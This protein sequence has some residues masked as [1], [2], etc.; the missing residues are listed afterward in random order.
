LLDTLGVPRDRRGIVL[1]C[2]YVMVAAVGL[3][4]LLTAP[5]DAIG[6]GYLA[7]AAVGYLFIQ[8]RGMSTFLWLLVAGGGGAVVLS[9]ARSGWVEFGL[10]LALALVSLTPLPKIH[11]AESGAPLAETTPLTGSLNGAS[12]G[13]SSSFLEVSSP[14]TSGILEED[15]PDSPTN[16]AVARPR[17]RIRAIG[18]LVLICGEEDLAADLEDKSVLAFLFKF[19]LARWVLGEPQ[20]A[21]DAMANELSPRVPQSSARERLRKQLHE[22]QRNTAPV[23]A[24]LLRTNRTHVWFEFEQA[25]SDV[26]HLRDLCARLRQRGYLVDSELALEIEGMLQETSQEFLAGFEELERRVNQADGTAGQTVAAA[27]LVIANQRAELVR[28]L[29]EYHDAM[30]HPEA[31]IPHLQA[32]IE[33][34]QDRQ[35]L[36]R[37]LVAAYLKTGQFARASDVRRHFSF[38]QGG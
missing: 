27:R 25:E 21:R 17:L 24:S 23:I 18:R 19:L 2:G 33:V 5:G 22:L 13:H 34:L 26:A 3:V 6:W 1:L 7:V 37:L 16:G 28:A 32:A 11:R 8:T 35:D 15:Q 4:A 12:N 31:A 38:E 10:G 30:G 9:G 29:A 14:P 36:G 20:V